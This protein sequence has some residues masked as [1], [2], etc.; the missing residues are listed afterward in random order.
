MQK[1][2]IKKYI[3]FWEILKTQISNSKIVYLSV[4]NLSFLYLPKYR[5]FF[6]GLFCVHSSCIYVYIYLT[7]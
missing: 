3:V 7:P 6:T 1:S 4:K 2:S 5:V